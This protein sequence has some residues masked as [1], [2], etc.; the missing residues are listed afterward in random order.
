MTESEVSEFFQLGGTPRQLEQAIR[1]GRESVKRLAENLSMTVR[2]LK[3]LASRW[4]IL[5]DADLGE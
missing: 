5:R 1:E 2:S 4:G 3:S